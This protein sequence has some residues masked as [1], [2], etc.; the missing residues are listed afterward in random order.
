MSQSNALTPRQQ[1]L[2]A[3]LKKQLAHTGQTPSLRQA[4]HDLQVSHTAVA[5]MLQTLEEKGWVKRDGRYSRSLTLLT[6]GEEHARESQGRMVPIIGRVAAGM[7]L[8]AQQEWAGHICV[9]RTLY[10]GD[11][12]FALYVQGNSMEKVGILD[13]D[14]AICEPRQYAQNGEIVVVLIGNEEAT[15]KRFFYRGD[16]IELVPENDDYQ[17][18]R[19]ALGSVLIQGRV[20]GIHRGP[21]RMN[22]L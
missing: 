11:N 10:R 1:Q 7:P 17:P 18:V 21:D 20:I 9:D 8:Y 5:S 15:V 12:L 4:A 3:Y 16:S 14:L 6:G 22:G 19:Y 13:G 2:L